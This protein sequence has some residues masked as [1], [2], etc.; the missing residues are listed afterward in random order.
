MSKILQFS[1]CVLCKHN[2]T[3]PKHQLFALKSETELCCSKI[4]EFDLKKLIPN[5]FFYTL[6]ELFSFK[7]AALYNPE[8]VKC[9]FT[10]DPSI[11]KS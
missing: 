5:G 3:F 7:M 9:D 2:Q 10:K 1:H 4:R 8:W 6:L 11:K